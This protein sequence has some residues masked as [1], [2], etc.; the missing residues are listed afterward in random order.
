MIDCIRRRN[1]RMYST[2]ENLNYKVSVPCA[3]K[4]NGWFSNV[5]TKLWVRFYLE[6]HEDGLSVFQECYIYLLSQASLF[7]GR[8][9]LSSIPWLLLT[10][11]SCIFLSFLPPIIPLPV[12]FLSRLPDRLLSG[13]GF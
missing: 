5:L 7:F 8:S 3:T 6:I 4:V 2:C 11:I 9:H 10:T 13:P 1:K 12:P